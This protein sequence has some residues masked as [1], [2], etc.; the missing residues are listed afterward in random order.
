MLGL[1][2]INDADGCDGDGKGEGDDVLQIKVIIGRPHRSRH[3]PGIFPISGTN[4]SLS[5]SLWKLFRLGSSEF[6]TT[7]AEYSPSLICFK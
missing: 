1:L 5:K 2:R 6:H 7:V 3:I 4:N